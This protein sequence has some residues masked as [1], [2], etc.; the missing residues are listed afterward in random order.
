VGSSAPTILAAVRG[1]IVQATLLALCVALV[2]ATGAQAA[3][4]PKLAFTVTPTNKPNSFI[5]ITSVVSQ[6]SDEEATRK[7]TVHFPPGVS[8][9]IDQ[10]GKTA[11][12]SPQQRDAQTCP[13]GSR[14]GTATADT[15]LGTLT[16]GVYLGYSSQIYIYLKNSTI[17]LLGKEPGPITAQTQ[18]RADGGTDTILDNLPTD[19]TATRFVLALD[20]PPRSLITSPP[21]CGPRTFSGDFVSKSGITAT[22]SST[23]NFTGCTP[24]APEFS[25]VRLSRSSARVGTNVAI[26]YVLSRAAQIEVTVRRSGSRKILGRTK[27]S[28]GEGASRI[29]VVT[30]KLTPGRFIIG[31]KATADGKSAS[32]SRVLKVT[33]KPKR[34]R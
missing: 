30:K 29:R 2:A 8:I 22:A 14:L 15:A 20:G 11:S 17:A 13:E 1:R 19:I 9:S 31:V 4:A 10:L 6:N 5:G 28:D 23:V 3:Y 25:R 32:V 12:C 16:G 21:V 34:R 7:A 18:F 33:P 27:F 26:S 24:E